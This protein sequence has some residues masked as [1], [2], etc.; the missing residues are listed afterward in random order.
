MK[1]LL[2]LIIF[3]LAACETLRDATNRSFSNSGGENTSA[4]AVDTN[5]ENPGIPLRALLSGSDDVSSWTSQKL[6]RVLTREDEKD[7]YKASAYPLSE[8]LIKAQSR[9]QSQKEMMSPSESQKHLNEML[10]I[11]KGKNCFA[12]KVE[13]LTLGTAKES[14]F[15]Q[16]V[17]ISGQLTPLERIGRDSVPNYNDSRWWNI[18]IACSKKKLNILNGFTLHVIPKVDGSALSMTW[19]PVYKGFIWNS[20]ELCLH[21]ARPA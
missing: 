8:T 6:E 5:A 19:N 1:G 2:C 14:N 3:P 21:E 11:Y 12:I 9:E 17:E 10:S 16:K 7:W 20:H 4:G 15:V 13:S 18:Y